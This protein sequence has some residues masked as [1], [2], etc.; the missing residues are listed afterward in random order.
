MLHTPTVTYTP[1]QMP[2]PGEDQPDALDAELVN[3]S[4]MKEADDAE[5]A[6]ALHQDAGLAT[7]DKV[8]DAEV[9]DALANT[10]SMYG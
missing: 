5:E 9:V 2:V 7:G 10:D 1:T 3:P 6:R 4:E 8:D